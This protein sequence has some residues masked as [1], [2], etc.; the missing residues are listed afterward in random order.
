LIFGPVF[1]IEKLHLLLKAEFSWDQP[2][3]LKIVTSEKIA[4]TPSITEFTLVP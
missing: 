3:A 1:E 4:K 2:S